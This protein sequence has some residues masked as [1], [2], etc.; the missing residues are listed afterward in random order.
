MTFRGMSEWDVSTFY[1]LINVPIINVLATGSLTSPPRT[2]RN[3]AF[4]AEVKSLEKAEVVY[5]PGLSHEM[6][7]LVSRRKR[8]GNPLLL[9]TR[10]IGGRNEK[11]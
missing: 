3:P 10:L 6:A 7:L 5:W 9:T 1:S 4:A 11:G 2:R 8:S